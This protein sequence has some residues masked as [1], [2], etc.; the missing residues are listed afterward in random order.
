VVAAVSGGADSLALLVLAVEAG[1][2]VTAVHVDHGLRAASAADGELV[3]T[4]AAALGRPARV[5]R[6]A[7]GDGPDLEARARD[8]RYAALE[9]AA[10]DLGATAVLTGHTMDDQAETVLVNLLRG[11]A[12]TGLA[13]IPRRRGR[14][15]RP[16]LDWRRADTV[17][18]CAE[19]GLEPAVDPMNADPRFTRVQLRHHVISLLEATVARD[20]VPVLA[21]QA[22]LLRAD[23]E[24]LD[25]VADAERAR[26]GDPPSA[27]ALAA[28]APALARRVVR[29]WLGDPPVRA[30]DVA[31]VL[32]VA[33]GRRRAVELPGGRRVERVGD[34][35]LV[36]TPGPGAPAALGDGLVVPSPVP[37]R[38]ALGPVAVD[39]WVEPTPPDGWPDGRWRAVADADAVGPE[40]VLR[41]W[42]AGDRIRP[43]GL[44]GSKLVA[45]A[46]AEVGIAAGD[47][48]MHPVLER[49]SD[50]EIVWVLGYRV[51]DGVRVTAATRRYLWMEAR[52]P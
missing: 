26:L 50:G 43:L 8:A 15:V 13:G 21:R 38:L 7:V 14:I 45:D 10:D 35:L 36:G 9:Q 48:A 23:A 34:A 47:R 1:C 5:V 19:L 12:T 20:L 31:A 3:A 41:P 52:S 30:A 39:T 22:D 29:R 16:L 18:L 37:G 44:G 40:L 42:R 51:A 46:L 6:V 11:A 2:A 27:G 24:L 17:A 49:P 28:L 32:E 25:A 4:V 33:D